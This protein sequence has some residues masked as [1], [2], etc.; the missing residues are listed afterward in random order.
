MK[1]TDK[2]YWKG[3][4]WGY[5]SGCGGATLGTILYHLLR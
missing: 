5:I 4:L 2:T 1:N 3:Y